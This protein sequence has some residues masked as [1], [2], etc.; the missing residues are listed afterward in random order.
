MDPLL[1]PILAGVFNVAACLSRVLERET[2]I[3][4]VDTLR[5][6]M[7]LGSEQEDYLRE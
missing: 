2:A 1:M 4:T 7:T 5:T 6:Q 3:N